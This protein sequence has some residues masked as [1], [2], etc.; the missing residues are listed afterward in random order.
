MSTGQKTYWPS[1][2]NK[3]PDLLHFA[4]TNGISGIYRTIESRLDLESD[5]SPII[6]TLSSS[7]I[8]KT[9]PLRLCNKF[10]NWTQFQVYINE[11][12]ILNIRLKQNTELEDTVQHLTT[13]IQEAAW[14]FTVERKGTIQQTNNIPLHIKELVREKSSARHRWQNTRSPLDKAHLNTLTHNL[15][16]AI[17]Q[18]KNDTFNCKFNTS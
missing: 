11:N 6:I 3:I 10:T 2:L 13:L 12:I 15:R 17:R 1:D 9:Q 16:S 8:C 18:A 5:H 14:L 4:I 7:P